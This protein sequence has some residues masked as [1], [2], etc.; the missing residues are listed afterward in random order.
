MLDFYHIDEVVGEQPSI[1]GLLIKL[2][3]VATL[4]L[5]V[6]LNRW[7]GKFDKR[8][9]NQKTTKDLVTE[10]RLL[11]EPI[12]TQVD[13][14]MKVIAD[15]KERKFTTPQFRSIILLKLDRLKIFDRS[16]V[17]DHLERQLGTRQE[18]IK[19]ANQLFLGCDLLTNRHAQ[20]EE[21]VQDYVE[22]ASQKFEKWRTASERQLMMVARM[23]ANLERDKIDPATDPLIGP[24][25]ELTRKSTHV[26]KDLFAIYDEL[27]VPMSELNALHR[28]DP[29]AQEL[30]DVNG[31]AR[32][33]ILALEREKLYATTKLEKVC[34]A[35]SRQYEKLK[36]LVESIDGTKR[37]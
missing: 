27:H 14:V 34:D 33:A 25:I 17:V 26:E 28:T 37:R 23:M 13:V 1:A 35:M 16:G 15:L 10:I 4:V 19:K 11:E 3:P 9:N 12:R 21:I 36:E 8:K 29:R 32:K 31:E 24:A 30:A 5:G 7:I 20:L 2:L 18:A 6:Y 22:A